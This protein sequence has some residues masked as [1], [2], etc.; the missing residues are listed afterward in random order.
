LPS[1]RINEASAYSAGESGHNYRNYKLWDEVFAPKYG[2]VDPAPIQ[3][4]K[5]CID[6][7]KKALFKVWIDNME[8]RQLA[9]RFK[10][11]AAENRLEYMTSFQMPQSIARQNGIPKEIMDV[12]DIRRATMLI[13]APYY[14]ILESFGIFIANSKYSRLMTDYIFEGQLDTNALCE[15]IEDPGELAVG[16]YVYELCQIVYG[17]ELTDHDND[18]PAAISDRE[19]IRPNVKVN[20][21]YGE[22]ELE[23]AD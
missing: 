20:I 22:E 1:E 7:K 3:T 15:D 19:R 14:L 17:T 16:S 5:I 4:Y 10:K 11:F 6:V 9:E 18:S 23:S 21:D 2:Y 8:D 13:M 12:L